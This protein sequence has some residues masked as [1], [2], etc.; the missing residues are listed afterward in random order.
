MKQ[1]YS[2][3]QAEKLKYCHTPVRPIIIFMPL[4]TV[5]LSAWLM[6]S[7][8]S[9][10]AYNWWYIGIYPGVLGILC[11][12]I[13]RK[14][15][16]KKNYTIWSLPCKMEKIW[17]A[18]IAVGAVFSG[19]S[20]IVLTVLIVLGENLI[21]HIF[22]QQMRASITFGTQLL[23][24]LVL[25]LTTLWMIPFCLFLSQ[26]IGTFLMLILHMGIYTVLSAIVSLKPYFFLFPGAITARVMCP[27]I[28]VLP[29]GLLFEPGQLTYSPEL[30]EIS[31]L[32]IGILSA[33]VW[34]L[35]CWLYSRKWFQK[36]TASINERKEG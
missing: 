17:D 34:F 33:I 10:D 31:G 30:G 14:D 16:V 18:K 26:K 21:E 22:K 8:F 25:W 6:G 11:S 13:G 12:I 23:T 29:N 36:Q 7:Y 2:F 15:K 28:K 5:F 9:V 27:L 35:I 32:W 19:I 20:V 4:L 3:F 1:K 24:A